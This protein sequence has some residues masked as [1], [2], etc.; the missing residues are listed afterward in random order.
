MQRPRLLSP[1]SQLCLWNSIGRDWWGEGSTE[2]YYTQG[3]NH[4]LV[5]AVLVIEQ[6]TIK[7]EMGL[8]N[9]KHEVRCANEKQR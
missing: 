7:Q 1:V 5:A 6:V 2:G 9:N 4:S 3:Q 8:E